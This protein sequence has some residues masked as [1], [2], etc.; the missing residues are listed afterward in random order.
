MPGLHCQKCILPGGTGSTSASSNETNLHAGR[1]FDMAA[2]FLG[3]HRQFKANAVSN[4]IRDPR[5]RCMKWP[6][7]SRINGVPVP[8]AQRACA[9]KA[10]G[11]EERATLGR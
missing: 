2:S 8:Q 4:A 5:E 10:Q 3:K 7:R 9:S 6:A 1:F 11:C